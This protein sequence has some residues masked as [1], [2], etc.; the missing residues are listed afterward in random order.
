MDDKRSLTELVS[1]LLDNFSRLIREELLLAKNELAETIGRAKN[2][3]VSLSIGALI[4]VLAAFALLA[5]AILGLSLFIPAWAAA[6]SI[7]ALL[8][9]IGFLLIRSSLKDFSKLELAP[10]RS[11][12]SLRN[13]VHFVKEAVSHDR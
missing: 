9:I 1:S 8:G 5:S 3:V 6:L 11:L 10:K 12:T 2:D 4:L 7:G 13:D